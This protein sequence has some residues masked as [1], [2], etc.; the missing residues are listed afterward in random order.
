MAVILGA[1][2]APLAG[3]LRDLVYPG[4]HAGVRGLPEEMVDF[5]HDV[6]ASAVV[7]QRL[8]VVATTVTVVTARE[9]RA[10]NRLY[11][12]GVRGTW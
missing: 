2:D 6:T 1:D 9:I 8:I 7:V 3:A 10:N 12:R 5:N 11:R 4:R